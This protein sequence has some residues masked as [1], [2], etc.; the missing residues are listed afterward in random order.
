MRVFIL[1]DSRGHLCWKCLAS[2]LKVETL[3]QKGRVTRDVWAR[4]EKTSVENNNVNRK[5]GTHVQ[6]VL[7]LPSSARCCWI[8]LLYH[9]MSLPFRSPRCIPLKV[10]GPLLGTCHV[11]RSFTNLS[12]AAYWKQSLSTFNQSAYYF[13]RA[14][15]SLLANIYGYTC[16]A[17]FCARCESER[18]IK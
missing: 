9:L 5:E 7:L 6:D 16:C 10:Q 13:Q 17:Q 3:L 15:C 8:H 12:F 1:S 18:V 11:L 2:R 4:A 14:H